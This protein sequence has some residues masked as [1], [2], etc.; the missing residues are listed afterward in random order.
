MIGALILVVALQAP[1]TATV[2]GQVRSAGE[3]TPIAGAK[4]LASA[5]D[6]AEWTRTAV[7][8]DD[9]MF[10]LADLPSREFMLTVVATGHERF[11]QPTP[12][13]YWTGRRP[14]VIYIQP[15]GA[16]R[17]RTVVATD[18]GVAGPARVRLSPAEVATLPGSQGDPLRALQN[19]PG[20]ARIPGGLGLLVLR[21]ASP[22]QSQVFLGEHPIPRAFH[23]PGL[24]SVVQGSVLAGIEYTPGNFDASRGN[25]VGGMVTLTPRVGRRDG[26]HG[27]AKADIMSLGALLEGPV[28]KG[29]FLIA[30]QRG[31]LD[32]ILRRVS[33]LTGADYGQPRNF[34]YQMI[35]DQPVGP[36]ATLTTRVLGARDEFN[37]PF[38]AFNNVGIRSEFHRVDLVYRKRHGTWDF[39]LAPAFRLDNGGLSTERTI[40]RRTDTVGLL[41]AEMSARASPRLQWTLGVDTQLDGY[42][43]QTRGALYFE[44]N[45]PPP[46]P[47]DFRG[48]A[49]NSGFYATAEATLGRLR[50]APGVRTSLFT[51]P[52]DSRVFAVDPRVIGRVTLHPRVALVFGAGLYSQPAAH[53]RSAVGTLIPGI[54]LPAWSTYVDN[55]INYT[56]DGSV[57][58]IPGIV[59]YLDLR[60]GLDP[61]RPIGLTRAVQ[62]SGGVHVDLPGSLALDSTVFFR[63]VR[64]GYKTVP[65]MDTIVPP[66]TGTLT[67]GVEVLLRRDLSRRV[68][69]WISYTWMRADHG[70]WDGYT[71]TDR[72]PNSFDQRHNLAVVAQLKLPRRWEFGGRF[73]VVTGLPYTPIVGGVSMLNF[74]GTDSV[75]SVPIFGGLNSAHMPTFHQLD[76]RLDKTWVLRRSIVAAY[77]DVQNVYNRQNAEVMQYNRTYSSTAAVYGVPILPVIGMQVRY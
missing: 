53:S 9:G 56:A 2:H 38:S 49:S 65:D 51:G 74:G 64:D 54:G 66:D 33:K 17:Y 8:G 13:K 31:Y 25:A 52:A 10:T 61:N 5:R 18:R 46:T 14:P 43:S 26:I 48:F 47:T 27:L 22:N 3:R 45:V 1:A 37:I 40:D 59:R 7:S 58:V 75:T 41:R 57:L 21:G 12:A 77:L 76:L 4:V 20:A 70:V 30:A 36:G 62:V 11:D 35:F 60:L 63:G 73:R 69:G 50:I 67:Y 16:G 24:A 71:L 72:V 42:R 68:Y 6:G 34:D 29:S 32:W 19:L 28:G 15:T 55:S 44:P 39:L 23:F